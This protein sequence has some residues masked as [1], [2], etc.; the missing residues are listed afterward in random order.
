MTDL[1]VTE[2]GELKDIADSLA[3]N[4]FTAL[5][6]SRDDPAG[7]KVILNDLKMQLSKKAAS[8]SGL[9]PA[10]PDNLDLIWKV[11]HALPPFTLKYDQ[12]RRMSALSLA[13]AISFGWIAGGLVSGFLNFFYLGGEILRPVAIFLFVWLADYLSVNDS[14][15][16]RFLKIFG[17]SALAGIASRIAAGI[18]RFG[19]GW[20]AFLPGVAKPGFFRSLW[21]ML[22][23]AVIFIFFSG[24][25]TSQTIF[26]DKDALASEI[27]GRLNILCLLFEEINKANSRVA[28]E[29]QAGKDNRAALEAQTDLNKVIVDIL[30]SLPPPQREFL[31]QKLELAGIR[32]LEVHNEFVW[33]E[34]T[35]R[36]L[37]DGLGMVSD[38]DRVAVIRKPVEQRGRIEKGLVQRID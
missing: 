17:W 8:L 32:D 25:R 34:S 10:L 27:Q 14:S 38:G 13:M 36:Q 33:R 1:E 28:L 11:S 12:G 7:C 6:T 30:D 31:G 18:F 5:Q 21:L 15:R 19:S 9:D 29:L 22:G 23:L 37:Y 3:A 26:L 16:K 2:K 4:V 20:R 35:D 24:K